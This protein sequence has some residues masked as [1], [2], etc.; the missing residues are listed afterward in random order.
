MR[1]VNTS[2][3]CFVACMLLF[4][5]GCKD[6][7]MAISDGNNN[8]NELDSVLENIDIDGYKGLEEVISN[9]VIIESTTKPIML[10]FGNN[11]CKYCED[12]KREIKNN[13]GLNSLIKDNF[14]T[15]YINTSYSKNHNIKYLDKIM[16]TDELSRYYNL[17]KTPMI[18]WLEPNGNE[19]LKLIG[20]NHD[21]LVSMI[22]FIKN[23]EYK[24]A[25][26]S[27]GRMKLFLQKYS[28]MNK[29]K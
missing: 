11:D 22:D 4:N 12:L 18:L 16:K 10:I 20:Y 13:A 19:I 2:L 25:K 14:T 3:K 29:D 9:N 24:E 26:D 1:F 8:T 15:Y 23:K 5:I 28:Q 7:N 27:N 17:S 21:Y 6:G